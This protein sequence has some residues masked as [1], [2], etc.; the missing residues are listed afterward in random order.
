MNQFHVFGTVLL[1]ERNMIRTPSV[2][3]LDSYNQLC[4]KTRI[5][6]TKIRYQNIMGIR[7]HC[8]RMRSCSVNTHE[9]DVCHMQGSTCLTL[10]YMPIIKRKMCM[11]TMDYENKNNAVVTQHKVLI[12]RR[13][14]DTILSLPFVG[15]LFFSFALVPNIIPLNSDRKNNVFHIPKQVNNAVKGIDNTRQT[16]VEQTS[17]LAADIINSDPLQKAISNL[18][19]HVADSHMVKSACKQ[20][21]NSLWNDLIEDPE[22]TRQVVALLYDAIQDIGIRAATRELVLELINDEK[23]QKN[24][25]EMVVKLGNQKEILDATESLLTKSAH[26]ALNDPEILDHSMEFATEVVGDDI[27]QR[28]SGEALRKTVKYAVFPSLRIISL[29]VGFSLV[30]MSVFCVHKS[31]LSS[32]KEIIMSRIS[33]IGSIFSNIIILSFH[34]MIQKTVS[35]VNTLVWV[36]FNI[37]QRMCGIIYLGHVVRNGYIKAFEI[38]ITIPQKI[39]IKLW[40]IYGVTFL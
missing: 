34:L 25:T 17:E 31:Q 10:K 20:L 8:Q 16:F 13:I 18:I 12:K 2:S 28:S 7:F 39:G 11:S 24:L 6:S 30:V 36:I 35:Q 27:V 40:S 37:L 15:L 4:L 1:Q 26:N 38:M 21:F 23:I 29:A 32:L 14:H 3:I 19:V 9:V 5:Y 33:H 22:T